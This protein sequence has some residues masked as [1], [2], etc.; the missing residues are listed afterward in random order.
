M[1]RPSLLYASPFSPM[2]SG[3]SDYSEELIQD[4][5]KK[6]DI[7][8]YTD[9]YNISNGII[10]NFKVVRHGRDKIDFSLYDYKIY[11]IEIILLI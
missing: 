2:K 9:D 3:I 4:L 1:G 5:A 10:K 6:F 11:T 7:T 8:L